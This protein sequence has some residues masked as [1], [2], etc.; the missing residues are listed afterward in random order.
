MKLEVNI[1]VD[2]TADNIAD[3]LAVALRRIADSVAQFNITPDSLISGTT[4]DDD[5]KVVGHI[6]IQ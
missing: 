3:A 6:H 5:G 4:R 2:T 1:P